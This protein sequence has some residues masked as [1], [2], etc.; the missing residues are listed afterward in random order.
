MRPNVLFVYYS[1]TQ[2]TRRVV[3]AMASALTAKGCD[4]A[5]AALDF[6]DSRYGRRFAELPMRFPVL[7]I[8]G[9]LPAQLRR[10][11]AAIAISPEAQAG[12]YDLVVSALPP[13]VSGSPPGA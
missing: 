6:T 4:V 5:T 1:Y 10:K 8:V 2:Q 7:K 3:D 12:D 11:T 13:I 9:M